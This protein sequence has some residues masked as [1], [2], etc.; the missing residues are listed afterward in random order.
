V[1]G[2]RAKQLFILY[3]KR[4]WERVPEG[5]KGARKNTAHRASGTIRHKLGLM[6]GL[7]VIGV[8]RVR[9]KYRRS[10]I[11]HSGRRSILLS[12]QLWGLQKDPLQSSNA[13]NARG[14]G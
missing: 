11:V 13:A 9:K 1:K 8:G 4:E 6:F 7:K 2:D 12:C 10:Q 3:Q 14:R 5:K